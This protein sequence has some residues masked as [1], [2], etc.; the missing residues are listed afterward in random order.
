MPPETPPFGDRIDFLW[1]RGVRFLS[2][3]AIAFA[4]SAATAIGVGIA[5]SDNAFIQILVI[6]LAALAF[7]AP[8][9]FIII[10]IRKWLAH[11]DTDHSKEPG[12]APSARSTRDDDI[13]RRLFAV[14]PVE[15]HRLAALRRSLERSRLSLGS[16]KLDPEAHELCI[17]ID[18]RLPDLIHHELEILPPD[19][20]HRRQK[21]RDLIDLV[22]QF[23]RHCSRRGSVDETESHFEA[24][25]LRRRFETRLTEF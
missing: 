13:W 25:V 22:E 4:M 23:A 21:V 20:R 11:R 24:E 14:A 18:R 10:R 17:L 19:D 7:W 16:A 2:H 6:A 8:F 9:F 15:S 12:S 5:I 1:K 3:A